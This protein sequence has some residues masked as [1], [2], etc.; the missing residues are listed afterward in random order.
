MVLNHLQRSG[1]AEAGA[2]ETL[3]PMVFS[4]VV[5]VLR[6]THTCSGESVAKGRRSKSP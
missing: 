1:N 6:A 4:F 3:T 2:L 5:Y